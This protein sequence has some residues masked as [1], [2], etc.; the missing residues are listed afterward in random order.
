MKHE[1]KNFNKT[2]ISNNITKQSELTP[3]LNSPWQNLGLNALIL[4]YANPTERK[5]NTGNTYKCYLTSLFMLNSFKF[6]FNHNENLF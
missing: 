4:N 6:S 2:S 1:N 5:K 3:A